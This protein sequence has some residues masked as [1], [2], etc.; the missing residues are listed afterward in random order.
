MQPPSPEALKKFPLAHLAIA[1]ENVE[2]SKALYET[3]GFSAEAP[4][5][6]ASQSVRV[7]K[8][9]RGGFCIELLEACPAGNG[10]IAKFI[11]KKGAGL[12]HM[13]LWVENLS[14][15][16]KELD[17]KGI[18]ALPGYPQTGANGQLVAFLDPKC[19]G[20]VLF[21]LVQR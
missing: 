14:N 21:E 19:T 10:P 5:I 18:K 2:Q 9:H 16:L 17:G 3:L 6:V 11:V 1:C 4:E 15:T 13:A 12:H 20:G 8:V 7:I